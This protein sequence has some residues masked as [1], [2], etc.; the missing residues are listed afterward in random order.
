M[1]DQIALPSVQNV[2]LALE[3]VAVVRQQPLAYSRAVPSFRMRIRPS[4]R[5]G[6]HWQ[7]FAMRGQSHVT[8]SNAVF[9]ER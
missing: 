4:V 7:C 9:C 1:F 5:A 2:S 3:Y 8:I 6:I